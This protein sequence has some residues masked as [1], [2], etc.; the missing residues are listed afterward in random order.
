M[1]GMDIMNIFFHGLS[2]V[3]LVFGGML[4]VV[5]IDILFKKR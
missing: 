3:I 2:S 5:I 1:I 4:T